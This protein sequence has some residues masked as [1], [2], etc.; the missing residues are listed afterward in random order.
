[1]FGDL[2]NLQYICSVN[3][4]LVSRSCGLCMKTGSISSTIMAYVPIF[5]FL[6][7]QC[8][9]PLP[10]YLN[11]NISTT[12][13]QDFHHFYLVSHNS[14]VKRRQTCREKSETSHG[15]IKLSVHN[16][17]ITATRHP[18]LL[19]PDN[20]TTY[21]TYISWH[22]WN[23]KLPTTFQLIFPLIQTKLVYFCTDKN[24]FSDFLIHFHHRCYAH[25]KNM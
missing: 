4:R 15:D 1:M 14:Q 2:E 20:Q 17:I 13:D 21:L 8:I 7:F 9:F 16:Y 11:V 23:F 24:I 22:R 25:T 12:P 19:T 3:F 18:P 10:P 6:K 5:F